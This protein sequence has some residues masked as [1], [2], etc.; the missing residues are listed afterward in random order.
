VK[1]TEVKAQ[2]YTLHY[3]SRFLWNS[4]TREMDFL[5]LK[6]WWIISTT[7]ISY[8][9]LPRIF[10]RAGFVGVPEL[11]E[12]ILIGSAAGAGPGLPDVNR[13]AGFEQANVL[14]DGLLVEFG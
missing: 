5:H 7:L 4:S 11:Y 12:V 10:H 13:A 2:G 9:I 3:R 14:D 1:P 8:G 6:G